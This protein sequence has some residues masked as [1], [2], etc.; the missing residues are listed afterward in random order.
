MASLKETLARIKENASKQWDRTKK[1]AGDAADTVG[2]VIV[3]D[4]GG[5]KKTIK[6]VPK[7]L[8]NLRRTIMGKDVKAEE[9]KG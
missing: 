2:D 6:D 3:P 1:A 7:D 8:E 4:R 5:K 9:K